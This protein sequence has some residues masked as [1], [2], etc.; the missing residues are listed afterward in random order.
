MT[1][2]LVPAARCRRWVDNFADRH[3]GVDLTVD[4]GALAG[5]APDG[6]TFRA[7]LP[8]AASYDGPAEVDGFVAAIA[9]PR[10]LGRAAGAQGRLRGRP[11]G[12]GADH[13]VQGR[14]AARA[15]TDQGRRPEPATVRAPP[16]QP[17]PPG[18]RGGRRPRRPD[19]HRAAAGPGD[20]RRPRRG[21]AVLEDTRLAPLRDR[22]WRR[23]WRSRTRG[24]RCWNRPSPR[25]RRRSFEVTNA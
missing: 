25:R 14:A 6:S 22:W 3:G 2:V 11:A 13:G 12:G 17:G 20:R 24:A 15:G 9:V 7:A 8:F 4:G 5:V 10:R 1:V 21:E 16:G 19:P 18:L 23:G